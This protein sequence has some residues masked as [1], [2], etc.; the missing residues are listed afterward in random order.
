MAR[1]ALLARNRY[2]IQTSVRCDRPVDDFGDAFSDDVLNRSFNVMNSGHLPMTI[3]HIQ[4]SCGCTTTA[5]ELAGIKIDPQQSV[6]IPVV[7]RLEGQAGVFRRVVSVEFEGTPRHRLTLKIIGTVNRRWT[8]S[9]EKAVLKTPSQDKPVACRVT[10]TPNQTIADAEVVAVLPQSPLI[11]A[12][13]VSD[14]DPQ[15]GSI[16]VELQLTKPVAP[17]RVESV[18]YVQTSD[19]DKLVGPIP[20]VMTADE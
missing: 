9:P 10:L 7:V 5:K 15:T 12:H 2:L 4:T 1:N 13:V 3:A 6:N 11:T 16:I 18:V 19:S 20:V 14:R 8:W 17:E